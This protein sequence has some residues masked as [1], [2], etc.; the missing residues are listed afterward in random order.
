VTLKPRAHVAAALL[1]AIGLIVLATSTRQHSGP[2]HHAA[3]VDLPGIRLRYVR[4]G[5][6]P[7]MVLLHGYGES[8]IAWRG[9]FDELARHHDVIALD[10]P[11]FGLSSKPAGGY[12]TDSLAAVVLAGMRALGVGRATLLGHSMGGAIATAAT[13]ADLD[14]IDALV[15]L[16]AA[17]VG[18]PAAIPDT[19]LAGT[20]AGATRTAVIA[21]EATRT[22]F[23]APH[24]PQWLAESDTA[25]AYLPADDPA[26]RAALGS[27]LE[28]FDFG[29]LTAERARQ[30]K[31]RTLVIWGE[32]DQVFPVSSGRR[33]ARDLPNAQFV[34]IG[35]CWHRP[36]EERPAETA[37]AILDFTDKTVTRVR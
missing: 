3:Y 19:H 26:Y 20:A 9:V 35:R 27:V 24:D 11:G 23:N 5:R 2:R 29:Y 33:V 10:L 15:L 17:V 22:R 30:L 16:D 18:A 1:V 32:F 6:G 4:A 25:L 37:A 36:H 14:R 7:T 34:V 31:T 21:Y 28:Q 12:T 8:L 13:L